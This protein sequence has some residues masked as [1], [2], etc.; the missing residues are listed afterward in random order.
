M[1][2]LFRLLREYLPDKN[3][4][5]KSFDSYDEKADVFISTHTERKATEYLKLKYMPDIR[6]WV[7][8]RLNNL[9]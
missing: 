5:R 2:R 9:R 7:F 6:I 8:N 3:R 1:C 4:L